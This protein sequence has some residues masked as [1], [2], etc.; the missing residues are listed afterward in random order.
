MV[1]ELTPKMA[2]L[3]P[4]SKILKFI[5]LIDRNLNYELRPLLFGR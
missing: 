5:I 1:A 4:L 3:P 2:E